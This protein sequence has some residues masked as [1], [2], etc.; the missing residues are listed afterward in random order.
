MCPLFV[1]PTGGGGGG[2][3]GGLQPG[4]ARFII[5]SSPVEE[6]PAEGQEHQQA[7]AGVEGVSSDATS[8]LVASL[9][10]KELA[11]SQV[12]TLEVGDTIEADLWRSKLGGGKVRGGLH[13]G[14]G[15]LPPATR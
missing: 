11:K 12:P 5:P 7:P 6:T 2:G 14:W 15:M 13:G 9:N 1:H 4:A 10:H 3:G 8:S